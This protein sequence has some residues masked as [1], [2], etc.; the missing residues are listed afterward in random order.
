M[1]GRSKQI[2][3]RRAMLALAWRTAGLIP[4]LIIAVLT[5]YSAMVGVRYTPAVEF[6]WKSL[7]MIA[8]GVGAMMYGL[9]GFVV[10]CVRHKRIVDEVMADGK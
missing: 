2:R 9:A 1:T 7:V 10:W 6:P 4:F 3:R 5:I 8:A